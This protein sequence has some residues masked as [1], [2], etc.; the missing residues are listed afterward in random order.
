[1]SQQDNWLRRIIEWVR[2][3]IEYVPE[4]IAV[5]EFD[6][7]KGQCIQGEWEFCDRRLKRA[8]NELTPSRKEPAA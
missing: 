4:D 6:C 5:C 1:M 7:R 2:K 8:E 3:K